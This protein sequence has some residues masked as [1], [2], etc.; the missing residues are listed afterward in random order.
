[1]CLTRLESAE[2]KALTVILGAARKTGMTI[3]VRASFYEDDG[4]PDARL[5]DNETL[6]GITMVASGLLSFDTISSL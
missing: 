2:V 5:H 3:D 4:I 1:M 6:V